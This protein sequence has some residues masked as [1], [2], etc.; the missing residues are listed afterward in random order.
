MIHHSFLFMNRYSIIVYLN[1]VCSLKIYQLKTQVQN[2]KVII[3]IQ[4]SFFFL[5]K[6][7]RSVTTILER[8]KQ[9]YYI[10]VV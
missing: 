4:Y 7:Q 5:K 10:P 3:I 1:L 6:L 2:I 9:L 8:K